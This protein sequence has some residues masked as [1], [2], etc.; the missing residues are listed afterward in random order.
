MSDGDSESLA[1]L[2]VQ[3]L[4]RQLCSGAAPGQEVD[5]VAP[6][7]WGRISEQ[8][9]QGSSHS[10]TRAEKNIINVCIQICS[11]CTRLTY[12]KG[13][14]LE[15]ISKCQDNLCNSESECKDQR[16]MTAAAATESHVLSQ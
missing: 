8:S 6:R 14:D 2:F 10:L 11:P 15:F 3:S 13:G 16:K 1:A 7:R 12:S 4:G 5:A 9:P